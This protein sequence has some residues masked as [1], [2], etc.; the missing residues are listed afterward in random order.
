MLSSLCDF[1]SRYLS[2]PESSFGADGHLTSH[3]K[4]LLGYFPEAQLLRLLEAFGYDDEEYCEAWDGAVEIF[5][6]A[7]EEISN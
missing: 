7:E 4:K 5:G 3:A 2:H 6:M 1:Y